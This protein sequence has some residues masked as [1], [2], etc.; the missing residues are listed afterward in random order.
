MAA[1]T[2][3][4]IGRAWS[5]EASQLPKERM[6]YQVD[7]FTEEP[8]RG[9]PAGVC[10][11]DEDAPESWMRAVAAE[12]NLSETAFL[13]RLGEGFSIRY[14]TPEVEVPL[15]GHATLASA[16]ILWEEGLVP[17]DNRISFDSKSGP[18]AAGREGEWV[19]LDFPADPVEK[20]DVPKELAEPLGAEPRAVHEIRSGFCLLVELESDEV[21]RT[22]EPDIALMLRRGFGMVVVTSESSSREYDF[23]SRCF[24]PGVGIPEDPV[25]GAAHCALGPFWA[26]RMGKREV[27]G[28]QASRRGGVVRVRDKGDRVEILGR[29]VTMIR[30]KLL[31]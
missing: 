3:Q 14:F 12:M 13:R 6:I 29:T 9:N 22:L 8:F 1:V 20:T 28:Y 2:K 19:A 11:L 16:H 23:V 18:L 27:T 10:L 7:S 30:G 25:T 4:R 17:K 5:K 26:E 31:R 15:C 24:A 21:V